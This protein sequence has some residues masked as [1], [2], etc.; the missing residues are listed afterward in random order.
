M[1]VYSGGHCKSRNRFQSEQ[2]RL[3]HSLRIPTGLAITPGRYL[4]NPGASRL[5]STHIRSAAGP[6]RGLHT[7][8]CCAAHPSRG[9][10]V[11]I[12]SAG[13]SRNLSVL[14]SS[15]H[16]SI[17]VKRGTHPGKSSSWVS[18]RGKMVVSLQ[19]VRFLEL[20]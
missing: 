20:V 3:E 17:I 4:S 18:F 12:G 13:S 16:Q 15:H 8:R 2:V 1:R 11:I 9:V 7:G 5:I 6:N 19:N 14:K 10:K